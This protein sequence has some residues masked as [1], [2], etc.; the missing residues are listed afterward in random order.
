M[1]R[2]FEDSK[3]EYL[4]TVEATY[5]TQGYKKLWN[6]YL[7]VVKSDYFQNK[8]LELRKLCGIPKEGGIC[9]IDIQIPLK[10]YKKAK[11]E[12]DN[13]CKK[14]ELHSLD[15]WELIEEYMFS[16]LIPTEPP[17][18]PFTN[19]YNLCLLADLAEERAEPFNKDTT[20]ADDK[21]YPI[22]IRISP[23]ASKRDI[24]DYVNKMFPLIKRW[25]KTYTDPKIKIGKVKRKKPAIQ[26]RNGFI[27]ENRGLSIN[28]TKKLV[29]EKFGESLDYEYIGKIRSDEM[30][31]RKEL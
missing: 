7:S 16:N 17:Q 10:D 20:K 19:S 15:W 2:R 3:D 14:Y 8:I 11:K 29:E 26:E 31:K 12:I 22:A 25:Q 13:L 18:L 28:E 30:R 9:K 23:Y 24:V 6:Y 4:K 1:A 21:I 5:S 27:Y